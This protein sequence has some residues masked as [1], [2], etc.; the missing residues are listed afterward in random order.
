MNRRI[1]SKER[2]GSERR[3]RI[4]TRATHERTKKGSMELSDILASIKNETS[5]FSSKM[6]DLNL[7]PPTDQIKTTKSAPSSHRLSVTEIKHQRTIS[8]ER[9]TKH[10]NKYVNL[11]KK[12][13]TLQR[14]DSTEEFHLSNLIRKKDYGGI[15]LY[16]KQ[17]NDRHDN[18]HLLKSK[19]NII[20]ESRSKLSAP[21]S[22]SQSERERASRI[23]KAL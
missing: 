11:I 12:N 16:L 9:R 1:V 14:I 13:Y 20:D 10:V 22:N 23:W 19:Q 3:E 4:R 2:R 17:A 7:S 6:D 5:S 18:P 15:D 8:S 21:V